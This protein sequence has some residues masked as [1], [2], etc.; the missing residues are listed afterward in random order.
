[1]IFL[2]VASVQAMSSPDQRL[3]NDRRAS[4]RCPANGPRRRGRLRFGK[5]EFPVDVL[6]ESAGGYSVVC[7]QELDCEVGQSLLLQIESSWTIVRIMNVQTGE[8][9]TRLGLLRLKDLEASEIDSE[10]RIELSLE[11][12]KRLTRALAPLGRPAAGVVALLVGGALLGAGVMVVLERSAP[13][14][15]A[16]KHD[17]APRNLEDMALPEAPP[18]SEDR[19]SER[20]PEFKP[21][22]KRAAEPPTPADPR[23]GTPPALER[24]K[25]PVASEESAPEHV[26]RHSHPGLL[27]K[28]EIVTLLDLT[29]NQVAELRRLF[30]EAR[31]STAELLTT[32]SD[33]TNAEHEFALELGRRSMAVLTPGQRETVTRMLSG[34]QGADGSGVAPAATSSPPAK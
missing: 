34:A 2:D 17:D 11:S 10:P 19:T 24:P 22:K 7:D 3:V 18:M 33:A 5:R 9:N 21:R 13:L 26:I 12:L 6:D 8:S 14:A 15:E 16:I 27:L 25:G 28:P 4:F 1:L 31:S 23:E 29:R 30:E 20:D 32:D